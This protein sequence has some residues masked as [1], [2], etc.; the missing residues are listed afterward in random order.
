MP[1]VVG[2]YVNLP[3]AGPRGKLAQRRGRRGLLP[4]LPQRRPAREPALRDP[5]AA[6]LDLCL[7][8]VADPAT[9]I[10]CSLGRRR[11]RGAERAVLGHLLPGGLPVCRLRLRLDLR[12]HARPAAA[13]GGAHGRS[14]QR[15]VR[16]GRAGGDAREHAP[17]AA[18][19]QARAASSAG[20]AASKPASA[21]A[22]SPARR[23]GRCCSSFPTTRR[24]RTSAP[25]PRACQRGRGAAGTFRGAL[26]SAAG[27]A[28]Y[29]AGLE[30][31]GAARRRGARRA[32]FHPPRARS[33]R[34]IRSTRSSGTTP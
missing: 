11:H 2:G 6:D 24:P 5:L 34:T 4:R 3:G 19:E 30:G 15:R 10:D 23:T 31:A 26:G 1:A 18:R 25:E 20:R 21:C 17:L 16:V 22:P 27:E 32:E 9:P 14:P 13:R 8:S 28:R 29:P 33:P 7:Y 12:P